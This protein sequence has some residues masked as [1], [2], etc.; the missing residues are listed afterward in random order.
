MQDNR[1]ERWRSTDDGATV[2]SPCCDCAYSGPED[3]ARYCDCGA[4][5]E[6]PAR[7]FTETDAPS[8]LGCLKREFWPIIPNPRAAGRRALEKGLHAHKSVGGQRIPRHRGNKSAAARR[9]YRKHPD[10]AK[11]TV[12]KPKGR[13]A[14]LMGSVSAGVSEGISGKKAAWPVC[15]AVGDSC[16]AQ[17]PILTM[18]MP[19]ALSSKHEDENLQLLCATCNLSKGQK[20]AI[21][22][23]PK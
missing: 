16:L 14:G 20:H 18:L 7:A 6:P 13:L 10:A 5:V 3:P 9:F 2:L 12:S 1:I 23:I 11:E 17:L 8:H 19:L 21:A 22:F 4:M 15:F